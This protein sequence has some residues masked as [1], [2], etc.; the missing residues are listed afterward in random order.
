MGGSGN[1]TFVTP[2]FSICMSLEVKQYVSV[3]R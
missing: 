3:L 1:S 2:V